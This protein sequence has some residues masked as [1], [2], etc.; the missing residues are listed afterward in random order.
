VQRS[1]LLFRNRI[2]QLPQP[3]G[4]TALQHAAL[5]GHLQ[6]VYSLLTSGVDVNTVNNVRKLTTTAV[7]TLNTHLLLFALQWGH[8]ALMIAARYSHSSIVKV[9]LLAGADATILDEVRPIQLLLRIDAAARVTLRCVIPLCAGWAECG[10]LGGTRPDKSA[11]CEYKTPPDSSSHGKS[12]QYSQLAS[13][14]RSY[15]KAVFSALPRRD[16]AVVA[17]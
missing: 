6:T 3:A 10:G 5:H 8:T 11:H 17:K 1:L 15:R 14:R 9:L 12:K 7:G 4:S 2:L 16:R 13:R